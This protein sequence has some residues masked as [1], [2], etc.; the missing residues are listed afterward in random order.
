MIMKLFGA[1]MV[2]VSCFAASKTITLH[3]R[4]KAE[5]LN[6]FIIL[7]K[8]IRNKI[9]CYSA[10]INKIFAECPDEILDPLGGR[11]EN[12]TFKELLER[13]NNALGDESTRL[14]QE[15]SETF[16]KNYRE[17]QLKL[18]D[19]VIS[20]LETARDAEM[21]KYLAKKK[22]VNAICWAVGGMI[23]IFLL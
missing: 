17:R 14:L 7:T 22:T 21:K 11:T 9:D 5:R 19:G 1:A 13:K 10:P 12:M 20:S 2:G 18:C 4:E 6:S 23:I 15:F 8:Y 16:G 3:E